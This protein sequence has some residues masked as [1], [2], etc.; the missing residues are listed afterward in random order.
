MISKPIYDPRKDG[1]VFYWVLSAAQSF[2]ES[3]RVENDAIKEAS[4]K[5][6]RLDRSEVAYQKW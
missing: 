3:K 1:N 6:K 4:T 2:R 5:F